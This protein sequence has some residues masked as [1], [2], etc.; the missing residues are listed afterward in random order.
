[1]RILGS[2]WASWLFTFQVVSAG[3]LHL[4]IE[5]R[6]LKRTAGGTRT[7]DTKAT[8]PVK[9]VRRMN[10]PDD[11]WVS[12]SA[13]TPRPSPRKKP[14]TWL[15]KKIKSIARRSKRPHRFDGSALEGGQVR[16]RAGSDGHE[17]RQS[18]FGM[19]GSL[20]NIFAG[21]D[22]ERMPRSG[23]RHKPGQYPEMSVRDE[24]QAAGSG[25]TVP[26]HQASQ[27]SRPLP[28]LAESVKLHRSFLKPSRRDSFEHRSNVGYSDDTARITGA[29]PTSPRR[30]L[31]TLSAG[32]IR[33]STPVPLY[34]QNLGTEDAN[35]VP[36]RL[37]SRHSGNHKDSSFAESVRM[38][39]TQPHFGVADIS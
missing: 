33:P 1:M 35:P 28:E 24:R 4:Q 12:T 3:V 11:E 27:T 5:H 17:Q 26:K 6:D 32:S 7:A 13:W 21:R 30:R 16:L 15:K 9:L 37:R 20:R 8:V 23:A 36:L 38:D 34:L 25:S 39:T 19:P 10:D 14:W 2:A 31:S 22:K 18:K 29:P